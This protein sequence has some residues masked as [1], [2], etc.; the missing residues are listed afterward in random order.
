MEVNGGEP[1]CLCAGA[2][3]VSAAAE[4]LVAA[5][6]TGGWRSGGGGGGGKGYPLAVAAAV[7]LLQPCAEVRGL[8]FST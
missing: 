2:A 3:A 8:K 7:S 6:A 5:A 4:V 1:I